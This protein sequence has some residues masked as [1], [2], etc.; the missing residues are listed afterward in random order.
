VKS[1]GAAHR[2][3][4]N[5]ILGLLCRNHFPSLV[6]YAGVVWGQPIRSSNTPPHPIL[7]IGMAEYSTIRQSG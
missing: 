2:R 1:A 5:G 3:S 7:K 6:E 4:V